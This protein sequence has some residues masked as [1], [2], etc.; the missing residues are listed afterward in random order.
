MKQIIGGHW[1]VVALWRLFLIGWMIASPW[2]CAA[3]ETKETFDEQ[4]LKQIAQSMNPKLKVCGD[5]YS[6][7]CDN[8][9]G[10]ELIKILEEKIQ[11]ETMVTLEELYRTSEPKFL[12]ELYNYYAAYK[13]V[14]STEPMEYLKWLRIYENMQWSLMENKTMTA[15]KKPWKWNVQWIELL[16]QLRRFGFNDLFFLED[17]IKSKQDPYRGVIELRNPDLSYL[18]DFEQ[19]AFVLDNLVDEDLVETLAMFQSELSKFTLEL[20]QDEEKDEFNYRY[21]NMESSS[22]IEGKIMALKDLYMPWLNKYLQIILHQSTIDPNMPIQVQS[23]KYLKRIYS[24]LSKYDNEMLCDYIQI[25][26]LI[27]LMKGDRVH[28]K[29]DAATNI[30]KNFPLILQWIHGRIHAAELQNSVGVI[31]KL[32]TNLKENFRKSLQNRALSPPLVEYIT[33]KLNSLQLVIFDKSPMDLEF[34]Y[35]GLNFVST[36]YYGNR[37]RLQ[38]FKFQVEHSMLH[39]VYKRNSIEYLDFRPKAEGD[40]K[41][42]PYPL[43]MLY[44]R[45]NIIFLPLTLLQEPFYQSNMGDLFAYSSLGF[46]LAHEITKSFDSQHLQID[47]NGIVRTSIDGLTKTEDGDDDEPDYSKDPVI[48]DLAGLNLA[49]TTFAKHH[50]A[51]LPQTVSLRNAAFSMDKVFFLNYAQIFCSSFC[52][53]HPM[54]DFH[55]Y[56]ACARVN[57]PVR[58]STVFRQ[59]FGCGALSV[60]DVEEY[61]LLPRSKEAETR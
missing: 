43:P 18:Y 22:H 4:R 30:R 14:E 31:Q 37:L 1:F 39:K 32:F 53:F 33:A 58:H 46:L 38:R 3:A 20:I 52:G 54:A 16:A 7:A 50:S 40:K 19:Q 42:Y 57:T 11:S 25:K 59:V 28:Y 41:D 27:F 5:F 56:D 17:I 44:P 35:A 45:L 29:N 26:F 34:Y 51:I 12:R 13:E 21:L 9:Q 48:D 49:Y 47:A 6:Y 2:W 61:A 24:F 60:E 36:E 15:E 8:W 55:S 10:E 23:V